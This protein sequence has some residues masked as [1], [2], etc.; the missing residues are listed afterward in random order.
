MVE[1]EIETAIQKI[2]L[3]KLH[4]DGP[5]L[6]I[7][8]GG[9]GLVSRIEG[10][11]VCAVDIRL[12]EIREAQIHGPPANWFVGDGQALCFQ[13]NV[14]DVV[15][16][17][18]SLGYMSD[19]SIKTNVL[20]EAHR[21]LGKGGKLSIL[22]SNIPKSCKRL[23]FWGHF[24]FPDGT[25]SQTGYG[26]RGGQDQTLDR[27]TELLG[28]IGFKIQTREDNDAWFKIKAIKT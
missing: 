15:T 1:S 4:S 8:G 27:M 11:K 25:V 26:V 24:T 6:D 12:S 20:K 5:I 23:T 2:R 10:E 3:S 7:G 28:N 22:A 14:F 21:V 17:W 19:W 16:L 13:N 18:F 9:E